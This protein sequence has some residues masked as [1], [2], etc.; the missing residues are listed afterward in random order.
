MNDQTAQTTD[1]AGVERTPTGEI[2]DQKTSPQPTDSGE[3]GTSKSS[4][5]S[6]GKSL[7]NQ[8]KEGGED[9][10]PAGAP[11]KYED[12]TAP[13]NFEIDKEALGEALPLFKELGLT[14][15]QAQKLVDFYAKT[16]AKS[17]ADLAQFVEDT[18][19]K[20]VDE[21][22]A[23]PEIG[24]SKLGQVKATISKMLDGLGDRKLA[25]SFREAMDMTGAGNN[26]AFIRVLYQLSRQVTEGAHVSGEPRGGAGSKP[27]SAA[28]AMYPNLPSTG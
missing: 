1:E 12:F 14:Q 8:G 13:E 15:A 18:Q 28:A 10:E 21:V 24:G 19:K 6:S 9:K 25:T 26:P 7:L 11:E 2:Q 20:W 5:G 17:S 16:S 22:N 4:D 27:K 3:Q 23:D